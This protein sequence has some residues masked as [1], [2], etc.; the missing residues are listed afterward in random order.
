[1]YIYMH[2]C[3]GH[4]YYYDIINP[5]TIILPTPVTSSLALQPFLL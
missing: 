2:A 4:F 3:I 1:M 5:F